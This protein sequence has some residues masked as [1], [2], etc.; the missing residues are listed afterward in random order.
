M[1]S[2]DNHSLSS[3]E[4][5]QQKLKPNSD[6]RATLTEYQM[7]PFARAA[8]AQAA[9]T[10]AARVP[11]GI[12]FAMPFLPKPRP[13][14]RAKNHLAHTPKGPTKQPKNS[15]ALLPPSSNSFAAKVPNKPHNITSISKRITMNVT[16]KRD[17]FEVYGL[18]HVFVL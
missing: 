10:F 8:I 9:I 13:L 16:K 5:R 18:R 12:H 3:H 2:T 4:T 7:P 11:N 17:S 6:N 15:W 1:P 14:K